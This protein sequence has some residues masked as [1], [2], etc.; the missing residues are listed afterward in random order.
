MRALLICGILQ[1]AGNLAY[2]LQALAGHRSMRWRCAWH[3]RT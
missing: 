3:W 2:V 1:S